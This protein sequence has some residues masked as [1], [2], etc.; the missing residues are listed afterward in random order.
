MLRQCALGLALA[1]TSAGTGAAAPP[2]ELAPLQPGLDYHS[3]ANTEQFRLTRLELDMRVDSSQQVLRAVVGLHFKRLDPGATQ[4]ILDTRDLSVTDVSEKP[5]DVL[6]A[7]A[8]TETTWVSRPYHFERKDPVLGQALVI[9]LPPSKRAA[10]FIR[11][12]YETSPTAPA[13]QWLSAAQTKHK[14]WV[15]TI[16]EPI[17]ARSWIPLQDT[18][19]V[20]FTFKAVIHTAPDVV[21]VMSAPNDPRVKR[22]GEYSFAMLDAIPSYLMSLAVGDLAYQETGPRTG[23]YAPKALLKDAVREFADTE[24]MLAA[25]ERLLGAYRFDRHHVVVMPRA[26]PLGALGVPRVSMVSPTAIAGDKSG[27]AVIAQAVARSWSGDL[28]S[29]ATW[30]DLWLDEG[31]TGY[32]AGRIMAAVYGE[33]RAA[34]L[35]ARAVAALRADLGRLDPPDQRLTPDLRARDPESAFTEV[36]AIKG[37]LFFEYLDAR[38]GRERFDEFLRAYEDHFAF[39][40]ITTE[41]FTKYL[42]DNLLARYPGIVTRADVAAWIQ[43]PG[44][45]PTAVLPSP[46]AD[47]GAF[48]PVD[49]V[50]ASWATGAVPA[51]KLPVKSWAP[52]QWYRFLDT[53][54]TPLPAARMAELDEAFKFTGSA[55]AEMQARWFAV[56][57]RSRYQPASAR[58]ESYLED[59]GRISLVAP[60]Y[61]ELMKTSAGAV[62]AHRVWKLARPGYHPLARPAI[63]AIV[64]RASD[65]GD[66]ADE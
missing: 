50:R 29:P 38:F 57:I 59:T 10:E 52:E 15:Y 37:R 5:Q 45:P 7:T 17:A 65:A 61:A 11:I 12:E 1:G 26:F 53:L 39:Q 9:E 2:A 35:E 66:A 16:S 63:D 3:F 44:L 42:D 25:G 33:P 27:A 28:V 48:A 49:A 18:P 19:E 43:G 4:L 64:E 54:P 40:S 22:S 41:Q 20:R 34:T 23:V 13:L 58:L 60:L 62:Q 31:L 21:A 56:A 51:R 6:G 32:V 8:K 47:A 55:D 30:R 14:P 36:P 46:D 24:A